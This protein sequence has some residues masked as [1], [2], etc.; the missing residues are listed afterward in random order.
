MQPDPNTTRDRLTAI[1]GALRTARTTQAH[2]ELSADDRRLL[3]GAATSLTLERLAAIADEVDAIAGREERHVAASRL[4]DAIL[5]LSH[6]GQASIALAAV[7][8]YA[9]ARREP[10][11]VRR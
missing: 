5:A 6:D 3:R 4:M 11:G 9:R 10:T 7:I 8:A 2:A 1:A